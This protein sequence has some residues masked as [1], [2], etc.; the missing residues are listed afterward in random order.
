LLP[1]LL[2]EKPFVDLYLTEAARSG[3]HLSAVSASGYSQLATPLPLGSQ[4]N[5]PLYRAENVEIDK[6][7]PP[8]F[9]DPEQSAQTAEASLL[10]EAARKEACSKHHDT[11]RTPSRRGPLP[12]YG[13]VI[14]QK[15]RSTRAVLSRFHTR[16]HTSSLSRS[17]PIVRRIPYSVAIAA[18]GFKGR[19]N[20]SSASVGALV[21]LPRR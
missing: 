2:T 20:P 3:P 5:V 9:W 7:P 6:A 4:T 19:P 1:H 13:L 10:V 8:S 11:A 14:W 15:P 18:C 17:A 12:A 21:T 16:S